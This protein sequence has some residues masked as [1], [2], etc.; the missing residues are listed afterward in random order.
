METKTNSLY[1]AKRLGSYTFLESTSEH[2]VKQGF[3]AQP[4]MSSSHK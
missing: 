2:N 4:S 1:T 3:P